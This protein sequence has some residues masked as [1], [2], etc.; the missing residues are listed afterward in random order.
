MSKQ[1]SRPALDV[2]EFLE[3]GV[4]TCNK[5]SSACLLSS[6]PP[7]IKRHSSMSGADPENVRWRGRYRISVPFTPINDG[8]KELK[9]ATEKERKHFC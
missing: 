3:L 7:T 1:L 6:P 8:E 2:D 5:C 4:H 9:I